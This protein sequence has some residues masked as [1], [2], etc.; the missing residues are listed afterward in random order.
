MY[1][2]I[3]LNPYS[4]GSTTLTFNI[5][6]LQ[7]RRGTG[8]NPYSNGSTTLTGLELNTKV[9]AICLNPYSNGSTTLTFWNEFFCSLQ[10][11]CLNPYSNGS[12]TLTLFLVVVKQPLFWV[13]ILILMEVP[14]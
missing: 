14:L 10:E 12:T 6:L 5:L 7:R 3:R 1:E 11:K 4:N 13:L 8:L 9:R 2:G